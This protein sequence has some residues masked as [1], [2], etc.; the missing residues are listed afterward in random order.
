MV[1]VKELD[2]LVKWLYTLD[3]EIR[4]KINSSQINISFEFIPTGIGNV[5]V[6]HLIGHSNT[7][8]GWD[9][10]GLSHDISDYNMW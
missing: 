3:N 4:A 10:I 5:V 6:A 1:S 8:E 2:K 7:S 9:K